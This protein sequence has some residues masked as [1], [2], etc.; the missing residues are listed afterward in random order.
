MKT[1]FFYFFIWSILFYGVAKAQVS[2]DI[3]G[4]TQTFEGG[5][6]T[7]VEGNPYLING[8]TSGF[9]ILQNNKNIRAKLKFDIQ[10]NRLLF[11][12]KNGQA[13]ELE[14]KFS[15]FSLDSADKEISNINPLKF[16][17]GYPAIERQTEN[18]LYQI[19]GDGKVKLLKY[20]TK[21]KTEHIADTSSVIT[22]KYRASKFYYVFKN[23]QLKQIYPNKKSFLKLLNEHSE[24]LDSYLTSN[25]IDFTSDLDLQKLFAWYNSLN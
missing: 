1:R 17:K 12:D 11:L 6:H 24:Q 4:K 16:V 21:E 25:N 13:L 10:A 14:N 22:S 19:V 3:A 5:T 18:S 15:G 20:Y 8:W 7:A 23:N 9:V 2:L